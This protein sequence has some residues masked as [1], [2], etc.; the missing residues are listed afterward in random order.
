M[1]AVDFTALPSP[2]LFAQFVQR[3]QT[4]ATDL[5]GSGENLTDGS[6]PEVTHLEQ[7]DPYI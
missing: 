3:M 1:K 2:N 6:D 5:R 7:K 4:L